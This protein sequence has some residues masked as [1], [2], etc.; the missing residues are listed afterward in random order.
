MRTISLVLL[1][2]LYL[3]STTAVAGGHEDA[4]DAVRQIFTESD[5]NDDAVLTVDE[6]EAAG[7]EQFGVSFEDSDANGDGE[8]TLAE[9]LALYEMHHPGVRRID[10]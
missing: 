3:A 10:V 1:G 2:A 5:A 7:L 6:Y 8:I 4:K 9:Y